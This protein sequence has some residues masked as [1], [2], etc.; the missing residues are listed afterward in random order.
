[1]PFPIED[2][3]VIAVALSALFDLSESDRV[4]N[5]EGPNSFSKSISIRC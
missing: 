3:F 5:E 2:K 4:F 1:M